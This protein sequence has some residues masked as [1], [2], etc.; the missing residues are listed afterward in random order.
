MTANEYIL[1]LMAIVSGLAITEWVGSL[2]RLLAARRAVKWD[3][4]AAIAALFAVFLILRSWWITWR[5]FGPESDPTLGTMAWNLSENVMLFL[6]ARASL[7]E[8]VPDGGVDL[9]DHYQRNSWLIWGPITV[10]A[11]MLI[12]SNLLYDWRSMGRFWAMELAAAVG[13]VLTLVPRRRMH[14]FVVPAVVVFYLATTLGERMN[15]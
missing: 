13:V 1:G 7:P 8:S 3:W 4:L 12:G 15:G 14:V 10:G 5:S 9:R 11:L 2:Y 6:A